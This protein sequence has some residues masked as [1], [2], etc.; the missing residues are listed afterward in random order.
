MSIRVLAKHDLDELL[1]LYSHLH[2]TDTPLPEKQHIESVWNGALSNECIKYFGYFVD[3]KLVSSCTISIIPNLTRS[4]RP[5]GVIEN[6]VTHKEFRKL[7]YGR[8]VLKEA[9]DSAWAKSCYKV[10]LMTG[11]RDERTIRL[12]E[13]TGFKR[14]SKE[15]YVAV[16][17]S[18]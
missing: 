17:N 2:T 7:G 1:E 9:L 6:V 14:N 3:G 4:C 15:A 10:M 5:Y 16:P 8:A 18:L 13:S 11:K 12:Y